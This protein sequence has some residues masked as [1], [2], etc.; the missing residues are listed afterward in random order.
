MVKKKKTRRINVIVY[1]KSPRDSGHKSFISKLKAKTFFKNKKKKGYAVRN[2][3]M[4]QKYYKSYY[5]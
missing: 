5:K 4:T 2:R 1:V 3:S